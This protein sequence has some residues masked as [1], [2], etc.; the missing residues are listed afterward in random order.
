[1]EKRT[2]GRRRRVGFSM[3]N[4]NGWGVGSVL[5]R[6]RLDADDERMSV[7]TLY[8]TTWCGYCHRIKQQL[9]RAS[10]PFAEIDIESDPAADAFV[11]RANG[12]N[13]LVPTVAVVP[14]TG[15]APVVLSNPSLADVQ[16]VLVG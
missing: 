9:R 1:M 15:G 13:A 4:R 14:A 7:I 3:I 6:R 11:R 10:L 5:S 8:S 16:R 2:S 12:G